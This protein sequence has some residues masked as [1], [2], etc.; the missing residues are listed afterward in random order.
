MNFP[1]TSWMEHS[2]LLINQYGC[3]RWV[4]SICESE[5]QQGQWR[6]KQS[7]KLREWQSPKQIWTV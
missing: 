4:A 2:V 7:E 1:L 5:G 3:L 6:N